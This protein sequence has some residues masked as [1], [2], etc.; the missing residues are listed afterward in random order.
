M[1]G[2]CMWQ[3]GACVGGECGGA[4][5]IALMLPKWGTLGRA[6][7]RR[8]AARPKDV[9][10]E[11]PFGPQPKDRDSPQVVLRVYFAPPL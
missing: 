11:E 9:L 6:Q 7:D 2:P 8:S 5:A 3:R 1:L 10:D 4:I